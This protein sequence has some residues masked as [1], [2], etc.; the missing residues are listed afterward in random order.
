MSAAKP[1]TYFINGR[2]VKL[3]EASFEFFSRSPARYEMNQAQLLKTWDDCQTSE[4]ARDCYLPEGL[5][6]VQAA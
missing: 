3:P 1:N 5:E 2:K 4:D 6:I